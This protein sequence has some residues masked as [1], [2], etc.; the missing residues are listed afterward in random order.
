M[1]EATQNIDTALRFMR[2]SQAQDVTV[3]RKPEPCRILVNSRGEARVTGTL[4][5]FAIAGK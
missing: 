2:D 1:F 3:F 5:P 4:H